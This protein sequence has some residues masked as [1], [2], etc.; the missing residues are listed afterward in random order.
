MLSAALHYFVFGMMFFGLGL[1]IAGSKSKWFSYIFGTLTFV[2]LLF[3]AYVNHEVDL[4]VFAVAAVGGLFY[5]RY[6]PTQLPPRDN[7]DK[8]LK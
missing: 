7:N 8:P 1:M 2:Y 5:G 3:A 4:A 6:F